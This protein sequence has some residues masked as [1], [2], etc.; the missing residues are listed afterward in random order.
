M[1][2]KNKLEQLGFTKTTPIQDGVFKHFNTSKH[3]VGLAP[4]GTG[5]THA[6]LLPILSKL[7]H[8]QKHVQAIII[9][10]T[11]ELVIQVER[12]LKEVDQSFKHKAYYGGIDKKREIE[13]LAKSQPQI[14]ISTPDKLIEFTIKQNALKIQHAKYVVFDEADMMFDFDFMS[15]IDQIMKPL[16]QAK[17]LLF[18]ATITNAMEPFIKKYFGSYERID[19]QKSHQPNI[20]YRLINIKNQNRLEQMTI[21]LKHLNPYLCFIFVSKKENQNEVYEHLLELNYKVVN[22]NASL[23]IKRRKQI[24]DSIHH[25]DYQYVVTSDLAARGMDFKISH[26][27]HYDLPHHLE[28]FT[29]R[30]GR[31]ARMYES[32]IVYTMMSVDDHRIIEKLKQQGI[33]FQLYQLTQEQL[34]KVEDK[35]KIVDPDIINAIRKI[36]KPIKVKPNYK[37][38]NKQAIKKETNKVRREKYA[39][40]R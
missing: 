15:M 23:G 16:S 8:D 39:K 20:D 3:I 6:Y 4:T 12:M 26:I 22:L 21:L 1:Y 2:I 5:K 17:Y 10:P 40:N 30:S 28:F 9:V 36:K 34:K 13:K 35:P 14:L 38:K 11:N 24:I 27:I 18:S 37:K 25:L 32:G 31:T 33:D 7:D 29:H 19:T